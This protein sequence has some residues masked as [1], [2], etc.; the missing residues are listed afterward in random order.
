M[1][2]GLHREKQQYLKLTVPGCDGLTGAGFPRAVVSQKHPCP[3]HWKRPTRTGRK[4][5]AIEIP[6][7]SCSATPRKKCRL[8]RQ[9]YRASLAQ[10]VINHNNN[11]NEDDLDVSLVGPLPW[12]RD[13]LGW[14]H[15]AR[16]L[17]LSQ[18]CAYARQPQADGT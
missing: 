16:L 10:P 4:G 6:A 2:T 8:R 17:T 15:Q 18:A 9:P 1:V 5:M 14:M 11:H 13:T 3:L 12:E 7:N